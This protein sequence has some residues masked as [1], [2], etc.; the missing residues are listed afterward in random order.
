M[1]TPRKGELGFNSQ[2]FA[3]DFERVCRVKGMSIRMVCDEIGVHSATIS[4][5]KLH[6]RGLD[7]VS[8]AVLC[9]WAKLNPGDYLI[10]RIADKLQATSSPPTA[11]RATAPNPFTELN[12]H[13]L[14]LLRALEK[15]V[16]VVREP[17]SLAYFRA[18]T[19]KGCNDA[20]QTLLRLG[21][22]RSVLDPGGWTILESTRTPS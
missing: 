6:N 19:M 15:G 10:R 16:E 11:P 5:M 12:R 7:H 13:E 8:L 4:R 21:L 20:A 2:L 1:G 14:L 18:D 9:Q 22:A 3:E 17:C